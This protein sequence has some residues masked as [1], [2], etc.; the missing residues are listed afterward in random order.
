MGLMTA[1]QFKESIRDDRV[2]YICGERVKDVTADPILKVCVDTAAIDYEMAE[3]PQYKELATVKDPET[4]EMISRYY[5]EPK[6]GED[7]LKR[8]E[9]MVEGTRLAYGFT[10]PFTHD[11]AAD[12]MNAVNITANIIGN[13]EY[14]DRANKYRKYLQKKDLAVASAVTD[15][16]G[17]RLLR[18]SSAQQAH[19]DYYVHVVSKDTKGIIVRGA[20]MHISGAP[21]FNEMFV[22]SGR[23]M[24]KDDKD[25][26]LAFAIPVNTKGVIQICHPLDVGTSPL[27]F[28]G[29]M[30]NH[31]DS[32]VVF[33][34]VFVPWERV[35]MC[36]E[37]EHTMTLVYNFAFFHRHTSISYRIP[38]SE[39]QLGVAQAMAEYNGTT[40]V[41]HIKE[42]LVELTMYLDTLKSL[43]RA[44]CMDYVMHGGV[45]VP[46]P[47]IT[48]TAKYNMADNYH[49]CIKAVQDI[50]GGILATGPTYKDFVN[51]EIGKYIDKYLGGVAGIPT[52]NRL[53]ML[54]LIR[55]TMNQDREVLVIHGEGSLQAERMTI[56]AE[57]KAEIAKYKKF[58]EEAA[59]IKP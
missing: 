3:M 38:M 42:R 30:T 48:N 22:I 14:I 35:F 2:V 57:K 34:D 29:P 55:R 31:T 37:W 50:A 5:Y 58:A 43:A 7:L 12:V 15:V 33:D 1:E 26:A 46:N 56:L 8:H 59:G 4:G 53:R 21:Y 11:I 41:P 23:N 25:Y 20:K 10:T 54:Q 36:G 47:A 44:A 13:K 39:L 52:E 45:A 40:S 49:N 24:S 32:L 16:K 6:T 27:D 19:P 18:P 9:L 17:N 51:S 28:P